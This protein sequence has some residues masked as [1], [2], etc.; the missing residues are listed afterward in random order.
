MGLLKAARRQAPSP[1]AALRRCA[2]E[3]WQPSGTK[4]PPVTAGFAGPAAVNMAAL[5][6][7]FSIGETTPTPRLDPPASSCVT[8]RLPALL[9]L[10][11]LM[12]CSPGAVSVSGPRATS[13]LNVQLFFRL[14]SPCLSPASCEQLCVSLLLRHA[15]D[16]LVYLFSPERASPTPASSVS[17]QKEQGWSVGHATAGAKGG[18]RQL[19][20]Q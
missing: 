15:R 4:S 9:W 11:S 17:G 14:G 12:C 2:A 8:A 3:W 7:L 1:K 18:W 10:I 6:L 19:P 5:A 16:T 13:L 20:V